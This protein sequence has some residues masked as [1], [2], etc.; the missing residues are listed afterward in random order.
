M[1]TFDLAPE[2]GGSGVAVDSLH[3]AT[4]MNT[5]MGRKDGISPIST[6]DEGANAILH[7]CRCQLDGRDDRSAFRRTAAKTSEPTS[8]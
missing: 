8:L 2:L 5:A 7:P 3:P 1:F 6:V 4:Y